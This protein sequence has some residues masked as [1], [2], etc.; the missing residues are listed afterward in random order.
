MTYGEAAAAVV[1][2]AGALAAAGLKKG[3][4]VGVY[5][6]NCPEWMIAMQVILNGGVCDGVLCGAAAFTRVCA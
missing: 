5:G 4:R 6:A 1:D 3:A 2:A